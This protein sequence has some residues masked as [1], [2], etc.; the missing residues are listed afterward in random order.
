MSNNNR[1]LIIDDD[2]Y[3]RERLDILLTAEG[4]Q[5]AFAKNGLEG[6]QKAKEYMPD[7]ILLDVMMPGMNGF[8]VCECVRTTPNLAE[9]PIIMLTALDDRDSRLR[10]IEAGA[11]DFLSKPPDKVE[12]C[13]RIRSITRLNRYRRLLTERSRFEWAI[14]QLK[15]GFLL[16]NDG[17]E[18]RYI[19]S[20]A[21][22]YLGESE[23]GFLQQIKKYKCE[24]E[25]AW[26]DWP[27][28]TKKQ[29]YLVRPETNDER[30]LWLQ[31]NVFSQ[32]VNEQLVHLC[33]VTERIELRRQMW[34]FQMMVSH[35]LR[36]PLNA[37]AVL[38]ML[39]DEEQELSDE[40]KQ[41]LSLVQTATTRLQNQVLEVLQYAD[42]NHL[43]KLNSTFCLSEFTSVLTPIQ[44]ELELKTVKLFQD[45]NLQEKIL[46]LSEQ[47][48]ELVL[49]ELFT[50][51]KKFH[52]QQ[53]PQIE[54]SIKDV[55]SQTVIL[56]ISDD[57]K[58]LPKE[59][60]S[61]VW[62]PY[63]QHEKFFSGEIQG[64]G[65]GLAMIAR[66]IWGSGGKCQLY[67]RDDIVGVRVELTLPLVSE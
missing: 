4:Y 59:I 65:L 63:Y 1:L 44:E 25:E 40:T 20:A 41:M 43:L 47:G 38:P 66:L 12:L 22:L 36:T 52:P 6:L 16:L 37:F 64:M 18:I 3:I 39:I 35:K 49:R 32:N 24:P 48:I 60:L 53:S 17:D 50:N 27:V 2:E 13:T 57:G 26:K 54:I 28:P 45:K 8:Q 62:T 56:S 15:D 34:S 11:D 10:G 7:L 55:D 61:Q 9:V 5:L 42:T 21:R 23:D 46:K 67:N 19:N 33:N 14:E 30:P 51:A 58:H 31:V 29:R